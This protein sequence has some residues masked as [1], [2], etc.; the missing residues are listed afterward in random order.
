MKNTYAEMVKEEG[1]ARR[2]NFYKEKISIIYNNERNS[3]L[4]RNPLDNNSIFD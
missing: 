3:A 4:T 1:D 2:T